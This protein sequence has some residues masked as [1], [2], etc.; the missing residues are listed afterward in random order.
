[1]KKQDLKTLFKNKGVYITLFLGVIAVVIALSMNRSSIDNGNGGNNL[2]DLNESPDLVDSGSNIVNNES[3]TD[4][5]NKGSNI[6][7]NKISN[8]ILLEHD[9]Y[10]GGQYAGLMDDI[11]DRIVSNLPNGTEQ[12][13]V[14]NPDEVLSTPVDTASVVD[15]PAETGKAEESAGIAVKE[16]ENNTNDS[17]PPVTEDEA[18]V[19]AITIADLSFKPDNGLSWPVKGNV[20]LG[21]SADQA[22]YH[23]T[24]KQFKTNPAILISCEQG[25]EVA[26]SVQGIITD[27]SETP[28]NG[29]TV[30]MAIGDDYSLIYGQLSEVECQI[31]D[32][33]EQGHVFASINE[34]TKY[35][36][37]E[38]SHLYFQVRHGE[39]TTNPMLLLKSE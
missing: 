22:V 28:Q 31:G 19:S 35:Y 34:V 7:G 23:A 15:P 21:Y 26:A 10:E 27:I 29:I 3:N 38:G 13:E 9:I 20:I 25:T 39:E 16:E 17:E 1:M 24:L 14:T 4:N 18:P 30:T 2:V 37:V 11:P 6:A 36:S 33:I 5:T 32:V 8:D 12:A